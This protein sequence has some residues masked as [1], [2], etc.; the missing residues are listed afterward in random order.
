MPIPTL[1]WKDGGLDIIDQRFLP[2]AEKRV[3][4]ST[5]AE[6][7][8]A[9]ETLAVRGAPAI[10]VA[11][12]YGVVVAAMEHPEESYV[13]SAI[14]RLRATRP[15]AVNL[16]NALDRMESLLEGAFSSG[17]PKEKLLETANAIFEED[18]E[19]CRSLSVHGAQLL[20]DGDTVLT[21]CN[22]G[23]LAT[24]GYGTALGIIYAAHEQGK[25]I[26]VYAD[27]TRP[28]FQGARLTAWELSRSGIPATVICDSMAAEIM[29]QGKIDH[30]IV[31]ADRIAANGDAANK[32]GTYGLSLGARAHSVP[33]Y[34][35]APLSSFDF[36]LASG[37]GIPIEEREP[38]EIHSPF[39]TRIV[40]EGVACYN[41]AFDV[42]PAE[43][44]TAIISEMG[45]ARQPF[46]AALRSWH[47]AQS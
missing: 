4:L 21:H 33:F 41:P 23:G 39:G 17:D 2:A 5:V 34:V 16:F 11:A 27:E 20:R 15:T 26:T 36:T 45:I 12:A 19:T 46:D 1:E 3:L 38:A 44:I 14:A 7:A 43:H 18:M 22:A 35:A 25:R 42:T 40:P 9:I 29:K 47:E 8:D 32:I 6:I 37:A 24:A 10:G 30:V 31:G 13:R 28:L